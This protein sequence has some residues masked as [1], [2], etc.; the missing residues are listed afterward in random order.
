MFSQRKQQSYFKSFFKKVETPAAPPQPK[1]EDHCG[2]FVP[3]Q[4]QEGMALAPVCGFDKLQGEEEK[5]TFDDLIES[6]VSDRWAIKVP[7]HQS[8]K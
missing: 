7:S 6:Q 3:F 4:L 1:E 5:K 2:G 8:W